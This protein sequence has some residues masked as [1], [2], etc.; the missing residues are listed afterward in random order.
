MPDVVVGD[1]SLA[2]SAT[3]QTYERKEVAVVLQPEDIE[4]IVFD[5]LQRHVPQFRGMEG[6]C[7]FKWQ[8][9][10]LDVRATREKEEK[11]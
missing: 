7:Q 3:K 9:G 1:I 6:Y 2:V 4:R 5:W 11:K 8:H 10:T